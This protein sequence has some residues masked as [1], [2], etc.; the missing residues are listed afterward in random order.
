MSETASPVP[1]YAQMMSCDLKPGHPVEL[2]VNWSGGGLTRRLLRDYMP[3][4]SEH[5]AI[6]V[7]AV[8]GDA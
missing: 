7:R 5:S 8:P 4:V 6:L 3:L 1:E 2:R